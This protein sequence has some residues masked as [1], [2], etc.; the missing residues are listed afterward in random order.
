M[1]R[2]E[3][4]D[5]SSGVAICDLSVSGSPGAAGASGSGTTACVDYQ[6]G[7]NIPVAVGDVPGASINYSLT[8]SHE[9]YTPVS[10][11]GVSVL[12]SDGCHVAPGPPVVVAM[13][14]K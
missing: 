6:C 2:I 14:R 8:I 4:K 13:S 3:A 10:V 5:A 12:G 1:I 11:S 7:C 9:G